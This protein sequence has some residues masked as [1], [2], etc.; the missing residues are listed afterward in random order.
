MKHLT[1]KQIEQLIKMGKKY[2]CEFCLP[3]FKKG[4]NSFF[5]IDD[6]INHPA[7]MCKFMVDMD[8]LKLDCKVHEVKGKRCVEVWTKE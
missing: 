3:P 8:K 4:H 1:Q 2:G 6:L 5:N 7:K